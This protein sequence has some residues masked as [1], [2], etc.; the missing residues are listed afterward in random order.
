LARQALPDARELAPDPGDVPDPVGE[1]P[2]QPVPWVVQKHGDRALLLVTRRCHLYCRYCF[3]RD[4]EGPEEP[5]AA[6]LAAAI[7]WC[8][9]AGLEELILSGGD[10]LSLRDAQLLDIIDQLRDH[11]P[12]IRIHTRA[13]IT[14]PARVTAA[15][16]AGLAARG[17]VWVIVHANHPEE[18]S[19]DV[20]QALAHLVDAG[21]PVLNQSVLL[22]GVNDDAEVLAELSRRLVRR[23]VFPYYLH[24]TDPVP[25]N[26]GFRVS[27]AKGLQIHAELAR[28]VSGLAL[29]RYVIDPPDGS[30]KV[31]VAAW[32]EAGGTDPVPSATTAASP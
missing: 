22:A 2:L 9:G 25:G 3:R 31:P 28:K 5:S 10:P 23:R 27:L 24:H 29:P 17:P 18:L 26:A 8:Q 15:L 20:D 4:Q 11:V 7:A 21:V 12:T 14:A 19:A 13:P 30:G 1:G 32:V 6:E 16:A